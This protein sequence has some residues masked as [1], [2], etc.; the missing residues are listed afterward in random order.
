MPERPSLLH[1]VCDIRP[2]WSQAYLL[3]RIVVWR[4]AV[5]LAGRIRSAIYSLRSGEDVSA[6]QGP[7]LQLTSIFR[8]NGA[9][10]TSDPT[11]LSI[12][13][14]GRN[15]LSEDHSQPLP[16]VVDAIQLHH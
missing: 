10:A 11:E 4:I 7:L 5:L 14:L 1:S 8:W 15:S 16:W 12:M 3:H 2:D 9:A 6:L 13:V